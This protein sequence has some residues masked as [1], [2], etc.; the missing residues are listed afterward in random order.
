MDLK[1]IGIVPRKPDT[2]YEPNP[3]VDTTGS[4]A[5]PVSQ[6]IVVENSEVDNLQTLYNILTYKI[7]PALIYYPRIVLD[8]RQVSYMSDEAIDILFGLPQ[9][10]GYDLRIKDEKTG[11]LERRTILLTDMWS[12]KKRIHKVLG[13]DEYGFSVEKE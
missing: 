6:F 9:R 8:L 12:I 3:K 10:Q 4:T 1:L 5:A 13:F 2:T 7:L 11:R